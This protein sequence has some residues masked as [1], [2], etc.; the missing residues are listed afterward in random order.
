[1]ERS[2]NLLRRVAGWVKSTF[3]RGWRNII[4]RDSLL[5]TVI[6]GLVLAALVPVL[7]YSAVSYYRTRQQITT[8]VADQLASITAGGKEQIEDYFKTR[9]TALETIIKDPQFAASVNAIVNPESVSKSEAVNAALLL[10]N[11]F[12]VQSQSP[13]EAY[14]D[15]VFVLDPQ[16]AI[17][18]SSDSQWQYNT[19][20]QNPPGKDPRLSSLLKKGN[21]TSLVYAPFTPYENRFAVITIRTFTIPGS[22]QTYS[23]IA[24]SSS[25]LFLV[26]LDQA[27]SFFPG[28]NAYYYFAPTKTLM[29]KGA[30]PRMAD[31]NAPLSVFSAILPVIEGKQATQPIS[32]V[33]FNDQTVLSFIRKIPD[34]DLF[35]VLEV[36]T[37]SV[38]VTVPLL[39]SFNLYMLGIALVVLA[40]LGTMVS[41]QLVNPLL[42]LSQVA[43]SLADGNFRT[44]A[45]VKR[46]D[47]VG[48][49]ADSMNRM[50]DDLS[51]LYSN[52]E[53][54]V[55]QRTSQLRAASEVAQLATSSTRLEETLEKT[56]SLVNLRFGY[57]HTAIYLIDETGSGMI[58][59]NASGDLGALRLRHARRIPLTEET[60]PCWVARNNQSRV[61]QDIA[62]DAAYQLEDLLPDAN[63]EAALPITIGR[64]VLGVLDVHSTEKQAFDPDAVFV[65]QT[66]ANL[67]ASALQNSRLLATAQVN[68]EE[69]NLL[70]RLTR[71]IIAAKDEGSVTDLLLEV[72]PHLP[73]TNALLTYD[74]EFLHILGLYDAFTRKFE[75]NLYSIDIPSQR[76][77][78]TLITGQPNFIQDITQP[79]IY[80]NILSFFLRRGCKSAILLPSLKG[81]EISKIFVLG[82]REEEHANQTT[83]QPYINLA[84]VITTTFEKFTVMDALQQRLIEL[85]ILANF[86]NATSAET[87]LDHLY[88]VLH[89]QVK[90]MIGG[91]IG[92]LIAIY[93]EK[94][95][96]IDIP[97]AFEGG[98]LIS[99]EPLPLGHGL[100]SYIIENRQPLL[101]ARDTERRALELGARI[102]GRPARSWMGVPLLVGGDMVGAI[103]LQDQHHEERF[104]QNELN[105]LQTVAPQIATAIR[106]GQLVDEMQEALRAYDEE[107]LLI[108]TWLENTPDIIIVKNAHGHY[109]RASHSAANYFGVQTES[110]I[111]KSDYD[112]M[113]QETAS[114]STEDELAILQER[115]PHLGLVE[116]S[117][118]ADKDTWFLA[119]K[120]P[121]NNPLGDPYGLL[122]IRRDITAMKAS[123]DEAKLR[124]QELLTAAE[125]AREASSTLNVDDL[126][127]KAVNLVRDRFGFY[128]ASIFLIDPLG[129]YAVLR[130]STGEAGQQMKENRHRL[131]IGSKSIVGQA[132]ARGEA[133]IVDDVTDDPTHFPNPLLPNTRAEL[134]LPLK[135]G[136]R[137]LGALDVQSIQ[138]SAFN[139]DN[140]SILVILADQLAVAL[141]NAELFASTQDMLGKHRLLHQITMAASSSNSLT[142][143]LERVVNGLVIAKVADRCGILLVSRGELEVMA[144]NGYDIA[145]LPTTRIPMGK[146]IIGSAAQERQ[147]ILVKDTQNDPRYYGVE[148]TTRSELALPVIFGDEVMGVLNME[149][150]TIAAFDENDM[151]IMVALV[152]NIGAVIANWRL[153]SQIRRQVE[154]QQFLFNAAAKIRRSVDIETILKTSVAEIGRAMGANRAEISLTLEEDILPAGE[155]ASV[156][157]RP[158]KG[159]PLADAGSNGKEVKE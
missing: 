31:L 98:D 32:F 122:I 29:G 106:N 56:A 114:V 128:H 72:M 46:R 10:R 152:N 154:R 82:F 142:E 145:T 149:S 6:V 156:S 61:I 85:Q 125:I 4:R 78:D 55:E 157:I 84:E 13:G 86:S 133:V 51:S 49:L 66:L 39:D 68:L 102:V 113:D 124:A 143:A 137:V 99:L 158:G 14:F 107:R 111:G 58:L 19:F 3:I 150:D 20:G 87:D 91:D 41:T 25:R 131:A 109:V 53:E 40:I 7:L 23:T 118:H 44:R 37:R 110:I 105:L 16:G 30:E 74:G 18:A 43:R 47:E 112:L 119:S 36:P 9:G 103:V 69:T 11:F 129:Q 52:L 123:E 90:E 67:V 144:I 26:V 12:I 115:Q 80:D 138:T 96:E 38:F 83:L 127:E 130:E 89:T 59:K 71:Q 159:S 34:T 8:L 42:H 151:E 27:I 155:A 28:A 1:M 134:A 63:S 73:S 94:R 65:L 116:K 101:L 77:H 141:N 126:L 50:A 5:R 17:I 54:K 88:R 136:D 60:I 97:Y 48:L 139:Q 93:D 22:D 70:Y 146:G 104:S 132:T 95:K 62:E 148:D 35:L 79:S 121:I 117:R 153:V 15:Q 108:N 120:I 100:T 2:E 92:F 21:S 57:Y 64:E 33:S 140:I 81:S 147:P 135:I 24:I 76:F 75:R 45:Q